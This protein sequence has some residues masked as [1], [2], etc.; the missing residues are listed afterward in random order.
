MGDPGEELVF[1]LVP[2][3]RAGWVMADNDVQSCGGG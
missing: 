2:F 1:N 3:A